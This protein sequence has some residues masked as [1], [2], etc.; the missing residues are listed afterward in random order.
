[1]AQQCREGPEKSL[2]Q[3]LS[4]LKT[5]ESRYFGAFRAAAIPRME[6]AATGCHHRG[7]RMEIAVQER[8]RGVT[9]VTLQ[10][11]FDTTGAV[12]VELPFN[13]I[14][15]EK[16][17][18]VVDL[19]AV[20]FLS[21]YGIRVL[22]VGAKLITGRGG[23]LAVVC[24]DGNVAKVLKTAGTTELIPVFQSEDTAI[25]AVSAP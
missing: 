4:L 2:G 17:S 8:E 14:A 6:E 19:S 10:G 22:L 25:A 24:P 23:K 18:V 3:T 20:T 12:Q 5:P 21:S 7:D 1:M 16:R 9:K 15:T 13:T 11:R